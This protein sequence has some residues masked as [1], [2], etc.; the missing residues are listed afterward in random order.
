[1]YDGWGPG[2][3]TS[4][5]SLAIEGAIAPYD[6]EPLHFADAVRENDGKV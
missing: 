4:G 1:M 3:A 2:L 5:G 6:V